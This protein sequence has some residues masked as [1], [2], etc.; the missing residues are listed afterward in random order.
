MYNNTWQAHHTNPT[1][2]NDLDCF[3]DVSL[4]IRGLTCVG[5]LVVP[6]S[7]V[8]VQDGN[9]IHVSLI[10][11]G[12]LVISPGVLWLRVGL[13]GALQCNRSTNIDFM[14]LQ[15]HYFW[16]WV[17]RFNSIRQTYSKSTWTNDS[18]TQILILFIIIGISTWYLLLLVLV[19]SIYINLKWL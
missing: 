11:V 17:W 9:S 18:L 16:W 12:S 13:R 7:F 10:D 1:S 14:V 2:H 5:A 3:R 6:V 19:F 4:P 8:Y 15:L